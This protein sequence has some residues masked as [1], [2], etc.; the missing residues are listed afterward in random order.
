MS[1]AVL[2]YFIYNGKEHK[3][4][5]FEN[6]YVG[7]KP[8]IYEVI[9]NIDEVPV[10]LE[11]HYDRLINSAK[12]LGHKLD[13][14]LDNVKD[15]IIKMI[16]LNDISNFNIKIVVNALDSDNPNEY[17]FFIKSEYPSEDL[18]KTGVE[19]LLYRAERSNPNAKV[20]NQNL[21]EDIN[22]LLKEKDCYEALLV[23]HNGEITE[24]SRSNIFF[25]K[26][27]KVYTAPAKDV[28]LGITRQRILTLCNKNN[29]DTLEAPILMED[30]HTFDAAFISG[31]SPKVLPIS[32]IDTINLS[33]TNKILVEIMKIYDDEIRNYMYNYK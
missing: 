26:N 27:N 32:K 5:E 10:F 1:E 19:T 16:K 22:N 21:R 7:G 17:Y 9:R 18:Y 25:I 8:S 11:E 28:L 6:F 13:L 33:T 3:I 23:N 14:S 30:L 12:I 31:T 15:N 20:I 2:N 4:S 29:I 24:G